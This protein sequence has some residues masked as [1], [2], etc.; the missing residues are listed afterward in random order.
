M[1]LKLS[2][3]LASMMP[4]LMANVAQAANP[5]HVTRLLKTKECNSCDLSGADLI[6]AVLTGAKLQGANLNAANLTGADL[7]NAD[8]TKAS[9]AGSNLV[10]ANLQRATLKETSLVYANLALSQLNNSLL[11]KTDLQAANLMGASLLGAKVTKSSFVGANLYNLKA[12][13]SIYDAINSNVFKGGVKVNLSSA[14]LAPSPAS[15]M[16]KPSAPTEE[17]S[18]ETFESGTTPPRNRIIR[19][20]R[21]PAWIGKP[22]RSTAGAVRFHNPNHPDLE[23]KTW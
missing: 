5:E 2:Y 22:L 13:N 23:I 19:R 1:R 11:N 17:S 21:I 12:N 14:I 7:S 9:L 6:G 20:Y 10:G 4:L 3:L 16:G 18:P 8:L 15:A